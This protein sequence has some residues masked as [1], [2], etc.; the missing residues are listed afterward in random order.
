MLPVF[1]NGAVGLRGGYKGALRTSWGWMGGGGVAQDRLLFC[2]P[3]RVNYLLF[4]LD[5]TE[6][7]VFCP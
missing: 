7:L 3:P 1:S 2:I 6:G 5:N 4:A